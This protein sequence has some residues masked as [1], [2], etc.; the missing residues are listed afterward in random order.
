MPADD[1]L[2]EKALAGQMRNRTPSDDSVANGGSA[3]GEAGAEQSNLGADAC[4][5]AE[6]LAAYHER[7]L[8][9][10][11]MN[12]WKEHIFSCARC[13]EIL[14]HLEA[15]EDILV[16]AAEE[17]QIAAV[18]EDARSPARMPHPAVFAVRPAAMQELRSVASLASVPLAS[19]AG[20]VAAAVPRR[21]RPIS[22]WIADRKS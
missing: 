20:Q 15:T 10:D 13:Q 21:R 4:P 8:S 17:D 14:S 22:Y 16:A 2:F 19:A 11:E 3:P 5:D 18:N 7:L 1:A 12:L 6:I 9:N